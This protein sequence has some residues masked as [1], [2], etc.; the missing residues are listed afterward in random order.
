LAIWPAGA[1]L[2][3]AVWGES[4]SVQPAGAVRRTVVPHSFAAAFAIKR[5]RAVVTLS[6]GKLSLAEP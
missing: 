3:S 5:F 4:S 1:I 6:A 2:R